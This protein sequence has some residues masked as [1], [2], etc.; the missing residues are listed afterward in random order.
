MLLS[1]KQHRGIAKAL[2]QKA[3]S[4]PKALRSKALK[5]ASVHLALARAEDLQQLPLSGR[6]A[7]QLLGFVKSPP[8][9]PTN[10]PE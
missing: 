2:R 4:L 9:Q 5:R 7:K 3:P 6:A 1:P 8:L 10:P